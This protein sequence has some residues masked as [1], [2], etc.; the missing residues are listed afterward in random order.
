MKWK[1]EKYGSSQNGSPLLR[2]N[3]SLVLSEI[4]TNEGFTASKFP[5][6]CRGW[7][8]FLC[9]VLGALFEANAL[10]KMGHVQLLSKLTLYQG[11][12]AFACLSA[13]GQDHSY[14]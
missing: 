10:L 1:M 5:F 13:L 12:W 2:L 6:L 8:R 11:C 4:R 3:A 14:L 9:I 7:S